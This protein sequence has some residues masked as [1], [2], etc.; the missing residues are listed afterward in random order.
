MSTFRKAP[1]EIRKMADGLIRRFDTHA[2]LLEAEVKIDY[3]FAYGPRNDDGDLTGDALTHHGVRALGVAKIVS[4]ADRAKGCGDAEIKLDAEWWAQAPPEQHEALLDHELHHLSVKTDAHGNVKE[5]EHRRP[6]LKMR[7]HDFHH[8]GFNVIALRHGKHTQECI[9]AKAV[10]DVAGQLY[11]P[12]L[13]R[14]LEY[15]KPAAKQA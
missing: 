1:D 7:R 10:M 14:Q 2:P 12:S 11:W 6:R 13:S 3:L 9:Q 4:S 15:V 5:D 8:R